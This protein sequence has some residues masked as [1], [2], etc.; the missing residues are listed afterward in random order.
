MLLIW[1]S[2]HK[3]TY[4]LYWSF[5]FLFGAIGWVINLVPMSVFGL[6]SFFWL[7]DIYITLISVSAVTYGLV[8]RSKR[9]WSVLWFVLA[10]IIAL[11]WIIYFSSI[12]NDYGFKMAIS[13]WFVAIC[14]QLNVY[15]LCKKS[16]SL[17]LIEKIVAVIFQMSVFIHALRGM[18][19]V[20]QTSAPQQNMTSAYDIVSYLVLPANFTAIGIALLMLL[21]ADVTERLKKGTIVDELSGTLNGRGIAD[22]SAKI[23]A[24]C[25][26]AKQSVSLILIDIDH[27]DSIKQQYG[28]KARQQVLQTF[29][30]TITNILHQ[31][32]FVGQIRNDRFVVV[33]PNTDEVTTLKL[34]ERLRLS[35]GQISIQR[36]T[37]NIRVTASLGVLS[38][39]TTYCYDSLIN[40]AELAMSKAETVARNRVVNL[41]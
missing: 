20:T 10:G 21:I 4:L 19:F 25:E 29:I 3:Q 39:R 16:G 40:T 8:I 35:I 18:L 22:I 15:I 24:N 38:T 34:A 37:E 23:M 30:Q 28:S 7:I 11:H 27:F 32:D 33:L 36:R 9:S 5:G 1:S 17:S 6:E 2:A 31:G 26:R 12:Q 14:M 41:I 13:P